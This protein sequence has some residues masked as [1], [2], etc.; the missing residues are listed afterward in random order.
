MGEEV[1]GR[2]LRRKAD[3]AD[4][5]CGFAGQLDEQRHLAAEADAALLSD[6]GSQHGG[7]T[8]I[9]GIATHFENAIPGGDLLVVGGA[10]HVAR[11]ANRGK[12]GG[13][14]GPQCGCRRA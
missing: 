9:H 7:Y 12:H 1:H 6:G 13:R 4:R 2:A 10:N 8:R 11:A 3:A 5:D 14:I